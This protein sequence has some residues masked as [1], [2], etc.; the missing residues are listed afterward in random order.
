[1]DCQNCSELNQSQLRRK[2]VKSSLIKFHSNLYH[3]LNQ[4]FQI[5]KH[6][7]CF[8]LNNKHHYVQNDWFNEKNYRVSLSDTIKHKEEHDIIKIIN[9]TCEIKLTN[10]G[11]YFF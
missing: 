10:L 1:M 7:V 11:V 6:C 4:L 8:I 2:L 5:K 3:Y 9:N